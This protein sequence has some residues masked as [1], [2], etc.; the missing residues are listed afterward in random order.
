MGPVSPKAAMDS[1][2]WDRYKQ[3][4]KKGIL[5]IRGILIIGDHLEIAVV[6]Q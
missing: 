4:E 1:F 6:I 3:G 5:C 2:E